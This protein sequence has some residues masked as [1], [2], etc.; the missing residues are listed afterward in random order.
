VLDV[1][2]FGKS[3]IKSGDFLFFWDDYKNES[4]SQ[5]KCVPRDSNDKM[6]IIFTSGSTGKGKG[7][8]HNTG[9][10]LFSTIITINKCLHFNA[11]DIFF[12][13]ADVCWLAGL[14]HS[15]FG[16]L[17]MGGTSILFEGSPFYPTDQRIFEVIEKFKCTHLYTAPTILRILQTGPPNKTNLNSLKLVGVV[18]EIL[19]SSSLEYLKAVFR[20]IPIINTYWQT[21]TGSIMLC[22]KIDDDLNNSV[23]FP[24]F[25]IKPLIVQ[26]LESFLECCPDEEGLLLFKNNWPSQFNLILGMSITN[27]CA[28]LNNHYFT[29]DLAKKDINGRYYILGRCD[30]VINIAAHRISTYEVENAIYQCKN[31]KEMA[32][33][34]VS[35][36]LYGGRL[37]VCVVPKDKTKEDIIR[38]NI[39]DLIK[40]K[41]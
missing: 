18:G 2:V 16:P 20:N 11:E 40:K 8:V 29:G 7:I 1:L 21:E 25:G 26:D 5:L 41:M 39:K 28:K 35:D 22:S 37:V 9:G 12:S 32:V 30:D 17:L 4:Y 36:D 23:G 15:L 24:V 19:T 34:G 38:S 33:I 3:D 10:W 13:T 14:S 6:F 27:S 31:V